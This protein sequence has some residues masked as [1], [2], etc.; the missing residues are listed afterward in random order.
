MLGGGSVQRIVEMSGQ[1]RS[2]RAIA[3]ELGLPRNTGVAVAGAADRRGAAGARAGVFEPEPVL[4]DPD[5]FDLGVLLALGMFLATY[6]R[7]LQSSLAFPVN[8]FKADAATATTFLR[9]YSGLRVL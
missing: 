7:M 6:P 1:G 3:T 4:P 2:I 9:E 8:L 5:P